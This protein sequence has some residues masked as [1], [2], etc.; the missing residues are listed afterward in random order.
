MRAV[1]FSLTNSSEIMTCNKAVAPSGGLNE[2]WIQRSLAAAGLTWSGG[3]SGVQHMR[4]S[5]LPAHPR[6]VRR[7]RTVQWIVLA[8]GLS[9]IGVA[10]A[11]GNSP[12]ATVDRLNLVLGPVVVIL[13]GVSFH[14]LYRFR[15]ACIEWQQGQQA[16]PDTTSDGG[17]I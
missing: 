10:I 4:E 9:V 13:L 1:D 8:V 12:R 6:E 3:G 11:F 2:F 15:R 7:M 5:R 14:T 17:G 16:E